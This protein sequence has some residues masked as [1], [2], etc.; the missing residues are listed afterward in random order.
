MT[1][2]TEP[3]R[4]RGRQVLFD[5]TARQQYLAAVA[6][7]MR[8][9]EAAAHVGVSINVPRRHARTDTAFA[10]RLDDARTQGKKIRDDRIP[11]SEAHYNNQQCR[12]PDCRA[13]AREG[14]AHRRQTAAEP[15]PVAEL[16]DAR[17]ESPISFSLLKA[18]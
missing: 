11:H 16:R 10:A 12:H 1:A 15:A 13:R 18:S 17:A 3:G 5:E 4:G 6:D 7:G 14:R 2:T 8:L 9:G